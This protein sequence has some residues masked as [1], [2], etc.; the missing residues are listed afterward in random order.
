MKD[1]LIH[2]AQRPL[3]VPDLGRRLTLRRLPD[4]RLG[5]LAGGEVKALG[6][7]SGGRVAGPD[8]SVG[9]PAFEVGADAVGQ[10]RRLGRHGELRVRVVDGLDEQAFGGLSRDDRRSGVASRQQGRAIIQP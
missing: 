5:L 10:P 6:R 4:P 2:R 7:C 1:E 3:R 8:C 9:H